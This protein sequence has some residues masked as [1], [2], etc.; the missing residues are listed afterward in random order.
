MNAGTQ[1]ATQTPT[2]AAPAG[3]GGPTPR[4]AQALSEPSTPAGGEENGGGTPPVE[5]TPPLGTGD[6]QPP[7]TPPTPAP[8]TSPAGTPPAA[9]A[10]APSAVALTPDQLQQIVKS[11][12]PP[13]PAPAAP[14]EEEIDRT[15]NVFRVSEDQLKQ[16]GVENPTAEQIQFYNNIVQGTARQAVTLA[17]F[18]MQ[19]EMKRLEGLLQPLQQYYQQQ[20]IDAARNRFYT[21]YPNLRDMEPVLVAIKDSFLAQG[22]QFESEDAAFKAVAEQAVTMLK[23]VNGIDHAKLLEGPA[24]GAAPAGGQPNP[25]PT[26]RPSGMPTLAG[27]GQGGSGDAGAVAGGGTPNWRK[28][29]A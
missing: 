17:A 13:P 8:T 9:P 1:S 11:V 18:A 3:G 10:P 27:G 24:A 12:A 23:G 16:M 28:A 15:F 7:T 6:V 14:T 25:Q 2:S 19:Q 4:W 29:L 26:P 5:G 22:K 21:R 20:A